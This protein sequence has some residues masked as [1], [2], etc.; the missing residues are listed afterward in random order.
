MEGECVALEEQ[1]LCRDGLCQNISRIMSCDYTEVGAEYD[2]TDKRN[3]IMLTGLFQ[4]R[5]GICTQVNKQICFT[6]KSDCP[7]LS[8][9]SLP[10]FV[11]MWSL[12]RGTVALE[13]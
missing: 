9:L 11:I 8:T 2:C 7:T 5:A 1:F 10:M 3:C 12:T 4:C 13:V 6:F